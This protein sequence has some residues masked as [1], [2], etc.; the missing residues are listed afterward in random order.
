[1]AGRKLPPVTPDRVT[2]ITDCT[3]EIRIMADLLRACAYA[4]E[5]PVNAI[6]WL[7]I[8]IATL[9]DHIEDTTQ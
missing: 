4:P 6:E 3:S 8:R 7:S 2:Q 9:C 1:M 5:T